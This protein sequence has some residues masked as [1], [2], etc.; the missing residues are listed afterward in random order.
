MK[1]GKDNTEP[2]DVYSLW[3]ENPTVHGETMYVLITKIIKSMIQKGQIR[4][5]CDKRLEDYEDVVQNMKV[6]V[7]KDILPRVKFPAEATSAEKSKLINNFIRVSLKFK[8]G[9]G[10]KTKVYKAI[11]KT[12]KELEVGKRMLV[13]SHE[14]GDI[15]NTSTDTMF[16]AELPGLG[17]CPTEVDIITRHIQGY[18]ANEIRELVGL[19][20]KRYE[21]FKASIASKMIKLGMA[22]C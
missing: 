22:E 4:V 13:H 17:F 15:D 7:F 21:K 8:Y 3:L 19:S 20:I 18:K 10:S 16:L 14:K 12:K 9:Y 2:F 6:T 11:E 1:R 5:L